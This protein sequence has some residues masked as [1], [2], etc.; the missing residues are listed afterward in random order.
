[1]APEQ[2]D[3]KGLSQEAD[4]SSFGV[5]ILEAPSGCERRWTAEVFQSKRRRCGDAA[6]RVRL[7]RAAARSEALH[8]RRGADDP[9]RGTII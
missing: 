5:L 9:E 4:V 7:R 8:G 1:M 3:S 6:R 2:S